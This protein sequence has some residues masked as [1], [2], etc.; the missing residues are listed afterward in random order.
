MAWPI[1]TGA[2]FSGSSVDQTPTIP[3]HAVGDLIV[4][5]AY[6]E[7]SGG[8]G[9]TYVLPSGMTRHSQHLSAD[10]NRW[11]AVD[12]KVAAST[13]ESFTWVGSGGTEGHVRVFVIPAGSFDAATPIGTVLWSDGAAT[14]DGTTLYE[15]GDYTAPAGVPVALYV[16]QMQG[17]NLAAN[18]HGSPAPATIADTGSATLSNGLGWSDGTT[19]AADMGSYGGLVLLLGGETAA[20]L[21][22]SG[23]GHSL[24]F[25]LAAVPVRAASVAPPLADVW[26]GSNGADWD[27]QIWDTAEYQDATSFVNIDTNR[28]RFQGKASGGNRVGVF[29]RKHGQLGDSEL[30]VDITQDANTSGQP[31]YVWLRGSGGWGSTN[32]WAIGAD[33]GLYQPADGIGFRLDNA[34]VAV[35]KS[36]AGTVSDVGSPVDPNLDGAVTIGVRVRVVGEQVQVRVWDKAGAEPGTWTV[37]Q[38]VAGARASGWL[39]LARRSVSGSNNGAMY[40]DAMTIEDLTPEPEPTT[41]N[42]IGGTGA[43][44]RPPRRVA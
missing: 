34:A 3:T 37:D 21:G 22:V 10:S 33:S 43:I 27:R 24:G 19:A 20:D 40:F 38:T 9:G 41:G 36:Q 44:R 6:R 23:G 15:L 18:M 4:A 5:V 12:F 2:A 25:M 26:T 35:I 39:Q 31:L 14:N 7:S 42:R 29:A 17:D 16:T 8:A 13:S 11:G 32:R 1:F 30:V 28:G